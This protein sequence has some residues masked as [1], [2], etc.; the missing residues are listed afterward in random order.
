M[1]ENES[2]RSFTPIPPLSTHKK[3]RA[4][5]G[6]MQGFTLEYYPYVTFKV[7][8]YRH[9]YIDLNMLIY[10]RELLFKCYSINSLILLNNTT[11]YYVSK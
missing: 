1:S 7:N 9:A 8:T 4:F 11:L 3:A 5:A 6:L 2:S 10:M